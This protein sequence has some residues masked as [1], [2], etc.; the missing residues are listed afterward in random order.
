MV[1]GVRFVDLDFF[2][3]IAAAFFLSDKYTKWCIVLLSSESPED[4]PYDAVWK[5]NSNVIKAFI[6][7]SPTPTMRSKE[8]L[9]NKFNRDKAQRLFSYLGLVLAKKTEERV[10][11]IE[12]A[13]VSD[14]KT[15]GSLMSDSDVGEP[16]RVGFN[17]MDLTKSE[18]E[19]EDD[20]MED[21]EIKKEDDDTKKEEIK[22]AEEDDTKKEEEEEEDQQAIED[23]DSDDDDTEDK[24]GVVRHYANSAAKKFFPDIDLG[25]RPE[26]SKKHDHI[27]EGWTNENSRQGGFSSDEEDDPEFRTTT[28]QFIPKQRKKLP[29]EEKYKAFWDLLTD[30]NVRDITNIP[31]H[32]DHALLLNLRGQNKNGVEVPP[33][34]YEPYK[35]GNMINDL[36]DRLVYGKLLS[37]QTIARLQFIRNR[38]FVDLN[39]TRPGHQDTPFVTAAVLMDFKVMTWFLKQSDFDLRYKSSGSFP[40]EVVMDIPESVSRT[41][42]KQTLAQ[43][44]SIQ[45]II[46]SIELVMDELDKQDD[47]DDEL[48][49]KG[50]EYRNKRKTV[51][52]GLL[53]F[54]TNL[55]TEQRA[56]E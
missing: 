20:E 4:P 51:V 14:E 3:L 12:E 33:V 7:L 2:L 36:V 50:K 37:E 40:M 48:D 28:M 17:L 10:Q 29:N 11:K 34:Y 46:H 25:S 56:T 9:D 43:H 21:E 42:I 35:D 47:K 32:T 55:L 31:T 1:S 39:G 18:D 53:G 44:R 23:N 41:F 38:R 6:F 52:N 26:H 8:I 24:E 22:E 15:E 49:D 19:D 30:A 45:E 16:E 54:F 27:R 5:S 13:V